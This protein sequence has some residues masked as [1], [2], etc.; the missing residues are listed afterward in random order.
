MGGAQDRLTR[1]AVDHLR[2]QPQASLTA[3]LDAAM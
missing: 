3:M 2:A 1:W